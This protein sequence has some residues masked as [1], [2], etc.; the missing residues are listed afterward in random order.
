VT[1][2]VLLR[3]LS[4]LRQLLADLAPYRGATLADVEAN[5]YELERLF[6]LLVMAASD[7]LFHKLRERGI[8]PDSYRGAFKAAARQELLPHDLADRLQEAAGMRNVLVHLY[9]EIDYRILRHSIEP[10]LQDFGQFVAIFE[11]DLEDTD[12]G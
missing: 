5:H 2:D 9:E 4:Y 12:N 7:I 8:T 6:E 10:A 1:P 3:K 11:T